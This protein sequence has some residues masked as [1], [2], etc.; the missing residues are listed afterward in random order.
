[1]TIR[2]GPEAVS[3]PYV[4]LTRSVMRAFGVKA[5]RDGP[6][7]WRVPEATYRATTFCVDGDHSS[8]SYFLA[9]PLVAGGRVRVERL[10]PASAQP[11]AC[12]RGVL[13]QLGASVRTGEDWIE[14][15]SDG[16]VAGFDLS[17]GHAPDLAPTVA[18]LGFF[19]DGPAVIR[20]VG[21]LRHKESDRLEQLAANMRRLGRSVEID[22][23]RLEIGSSIG[24]PRESTVAT[25]GDHRIAMAFAL[26][27]LG[28][29][30]LRVDDAG[31]VDKSNP[32]FWQDWESLI[33]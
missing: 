26:V 23:D 4:E 15:C 16:N 29:A 19:S 25:A 9:A 28:V 6:L 24:E 12:F 11:D 10:D 21:H 30:G 5:D 31:C 33:D 27:G 32:R 3:L 14:V 18:A 7:S 8:A 1:M 2:T 20:D 17:L 13:E 22:G